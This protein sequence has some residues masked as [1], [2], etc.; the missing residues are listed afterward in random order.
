MSTL[1]MKDNQ[2]SPKKG[3][4][5]KTQKTVW[6]EDLILVKINNIYIVN[7]NIVQSNHSIAHNQNIHYI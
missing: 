7:N 4:N 3:Q 2:I 6:L 5:L 1:Q